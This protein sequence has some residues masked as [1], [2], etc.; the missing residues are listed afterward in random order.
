VCE[1]KIEL[2]RRKI[3]LQNK[4]KDIEREENQLW[5]KSKYQLTKK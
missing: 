2:L 4:E 5:K 1:E 3:E